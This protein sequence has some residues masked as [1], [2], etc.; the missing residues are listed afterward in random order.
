MQLNLQHLDPMIDP[1]ILPLFCFDSFDQMIKLFLI[2]NIYFRLFFANHLLGFP[3]LR[4]A[5]VNILKFK[6]AFDEHRKERQVEKNIAQSTNQRGKLDCELTRLV[7]IGGSTLKKTAQGPI[8][9]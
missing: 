2:D 5:K 7:L 4:S 1:P 8:E 3:G 6:F 9:I